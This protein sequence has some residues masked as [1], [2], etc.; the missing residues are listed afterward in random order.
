MK[1]LVLRLGIMLILDLIL[2]AAAI[3]G[4]GMGAWFL[5]GCALFLTVFGAASSLLVVGD[6]QIERMIEETS[7]SSGGELRVTGTVRLPFRFPL[8]YALIRDEWINERN[9]QPI[10][11]AVLLLPLGKRELAF[12]YAIPRLPRGVYQLRRVETSAGD[13]LHLSGYRTISRIMDAEKIVVYPQARHELGEPGAGKQADP[14]FHDSLRAYEDG[15]SARRIDWKSYA[16][17]GKLMTRHSGEEESAQASLVLDPGLDE[18]AF[19]RV[20]AAAAGFIERNLSLVEQGLAI[21]CGTSHA[22]ERSRNYWE[23]M[24]KLALLPRSAPS[25]FRPSLTEAAASAGHEDMAVVVVGSL[26][27]RVLDALRDAGEAATL[28]ILYA[29]ARAV[30]DAQ[31]RAAAEGLTRDGHA[32]A[33]IPGAP[34]WTPAS[35]VP[36]LG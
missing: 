35:G 25:V 9:N 32:F 19:E 13:L 28:Q 20:V 8:A 4:G 24:G 16:R 17:S 15:D 14:M 3:A 11:G 31:E 6:M 2:A 7:F 30:M 33:F 27:Q 22:V 34:A 10:Q 12:R 26:E 21:Y 5:F 18:A 36:V 1:G 23:L 29:S